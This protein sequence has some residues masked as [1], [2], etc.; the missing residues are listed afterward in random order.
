[1][2]GAFVPPRFATRSRTTRAYR[3][4]TPEP[5]EPC[6][7]ILAGPPIP[8]RICQTAPESSSPEVRMS[9]DRQQAPHAPYEVFDLSITDLI[10]D[11][12]KNMRAGDDGNEDE[13]I[14]R[15]GLS[16]ASVGQLQNVIVVWTDRGYELVAGFRRAR[17]ISLFS[18]R[19][20]VRS[21]RAIRLPEELAASAR[22]VENFVRKNPSTYA[23]AKYFYELH[24]GT[25]GEPLSVP[26]IA[27]FVGK[28]YAP[29][30]AR[31]EKLRLP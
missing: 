11:E 14:A 7:A 19:I 4:R 27:L 17:A 26:H 5:P 15:L 21:I 24:N 8:D 1:M 10:I 25:R 6:N 30:E 3:S 13:E 22:L 2:P 31:L 9:N 29:R 23:I 16:I 20:G 12:S 28:R 18:E